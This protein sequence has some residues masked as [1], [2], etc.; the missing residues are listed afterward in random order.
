MLRAPGGGALETPHHRAGDIAQRQAFEDR[1]AREAVDAAVVE[2][3]F[4]IFGAG[5]GTAVREAG[6]FPPVFLDFRQHA[7]E[8]RDI[9]LQAVALFVNVLDRPRYAERK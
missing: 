2:E 7:V 9:A 4:D 5:D 1:S 3:L 6:N 8:A